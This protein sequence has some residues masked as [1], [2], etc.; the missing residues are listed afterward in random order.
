ML[1]AETAAAERPQPLELLTALPT[2]E[3]RRPHALA[4]S[5]MIPVYNE[6]HLV[7]ASVNRVLA[8]RS[9]RISRLEVII[10]DDRSKDGTWEVLQRLAT[11][12]DRIKLIRHERN[13][14]KG[15]ALRTALQYATGDVCIVHDADMEYN[16]AD[17]PAILEPFI[18]EGADAVFGS[19]YISAQYRRALMFRH[20]LINRFITGLTNWITDLDLTDVETCYK[21]INTRLLKS[22]PLRS[23][24]FRFEIEITLK[25]AKRRA[26]I[27]E[28]PIRYLPRSFEEG[29]KIRARDGVLALRAMVTYSIIDDLYREDEVGA[30]MVRNLQNA[31]RFNQWLGSTLR[32]LLGDRVLEI[33]AGAGSLTS[34]FIPRDLYVATET[35]PTQLDY[36]AGYSLGKPYLRVLKVDPTHPA[37]FD[38][39]VGQ[40]DTVV[41]VSALERAEDPVAVLRNASRALMPGGRII[42]LTA[43]Q[44]GIRGTIDEALGYR[45]RYTRE[46]LR[47]TLEAAGLRAESMFDFNRASTLGW[48]SNGRLFKQRA[49]TPSQLKLLEIIMPTIR[50]IDSALPWPGLNLVAVAVGQ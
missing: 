1:R 43:Q 5:V 32:P 28:V 39:L 46:T 27:F 36:L 25:L 47:T 40:F 37:D 50:R 14:G 4:L 41:L 20:T 48:W 22:L 8:L 6:R 13:Q 24:D 49:Y 19:R 23:N 2:S 33:G 12:D 29:K 26:R 21:A 42:I 11:T 7:T 34:Q 17:I 31:R 38:P 45:R 35:N 30:G 3:Q 18:E 44:P 10:V 16:P 9:E 15:A